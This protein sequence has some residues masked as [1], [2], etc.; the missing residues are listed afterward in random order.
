MMTT[1]L[2]WQ[3]HP[4]NEGGTLVVASRAKRRSRRCRVS[5]IEALPPRA[6]WKGTDH[7]PISGLS[8]V[9][10]DA[11]VI[12]WE[13]PFEIVDRDEAAVARKIE[14]FHRWCR[15]KG[16]EA[17]VAWQRDLVGPTAEDGSVRRLVAF[18]LR[19]DR[20][21]HPAFYS[22]WHRLFARPM[23]EPAPARARA[24]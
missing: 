2:A 22:H 5:W 18:E 1:G 11:Q 17:R 7:G 23:R 13:I 3:P 9:A 14:A 8:L 19:S 24:P 20:F 12:A 6:T 15:G 10:G 4:G 21:R 16:T